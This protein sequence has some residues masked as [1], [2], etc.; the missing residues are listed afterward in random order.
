MFIKNDSIFAPPQITPLNLNLLN[1][2]TPPTKKSYQK[3]KKKTFI[4]SKGFELPQ[5]FDQLNRNK[6]M[7]DG[8]IN[9][10]NLFNDKSIAPL[11]GNTKRLTVKGKT[12]KEISLLIKINVN[13]PAFRAKTKKY[14]FKHS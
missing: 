3:K 9:I 4:N 5:S 7:I 12:I 6:T 14:T 11:K 1:V 13:F 2:V 8:E 10:H